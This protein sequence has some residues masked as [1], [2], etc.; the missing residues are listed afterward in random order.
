MPGYAAH[1]PGVS[2]DNGGRKIRVLPP[3][4][5]PAA[6]VIL[7]TPF[8]P[9]EVPF[10]PRLGVSAPASDRR[11]RTSTFTGLHCLLCVM[12]GF[13]ER[14]VKI[15]GGD[16]CNVPARSRHGT[17]KNQPAVPVVAGRR[18]S[19]VSPP[20]VPRNRVF[21][22][23]CR[24]PTNVDHVFVRSPLCHRRRAVFIAPLVKHARALPRDAD[25]RRF[26]FDGNAR[27]RALVI[28]DFPLAS[29]RS[30]GNGARVSTP[31]TALG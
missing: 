6:T 31:E 27:R 8:R 2:A 24:T 15:A 7:H 19:F 22:T 4:P 13:V 23:A 17:K 28:P 3:Q 1:L 29:E 20:P 14:P 21:F 16:K 9:A 25:S 12:N 18:A 5:R 26:R 11:R 30:S 10:Q